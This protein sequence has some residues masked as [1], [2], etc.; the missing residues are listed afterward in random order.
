VLSMA[1]DTNKKKA[2]FFSINW[3]LGSATHVLKY[4]CT[5]KYGQFVLSETLPRPLSMAL[6][7]MWQGSW[8]SF[9]LADQ[10]PKRCYMTTFSTESFTFHLTHLLRTLFA[11]FLHNFSAISGMSIVTIVR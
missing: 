2:F 9:A 3:I 6:M 10:T 11:C 1:E 4:T 5:F 7:W 8:I